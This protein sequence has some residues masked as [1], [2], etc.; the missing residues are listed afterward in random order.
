MFS[1]Q[2]L[3]QAHCQVFS[4]LSTHKKERLK[5][6]NLNLNSVSFPYTFP[7]DP[8]WLEAAF[9]AGHNGDTITRAEC[10]QVSDH[11]GCKLPRW[12]MKDLSRRLKR[13]VYSV[14]EL[15]LFAVAQTQTPSTI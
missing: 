2:S 5:K 11:D 7:A 6:M 8:D 13:G 9:K 10:Q 3:S 12:L 14:P 15:K 4:T 1:L